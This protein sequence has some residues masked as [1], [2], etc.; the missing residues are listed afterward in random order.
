MQDWSVRCRSP[1][2]AMASTYT[3]PAVL[4]SSSL[5][6]SDAFSLTKVVGASPAESSWSDCTSSLSMRESLWRLITE[7]GN[8]TTHDRGS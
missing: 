5:P 3:P 8:C 4:I 7:F 2:Q 6:G 1:Q